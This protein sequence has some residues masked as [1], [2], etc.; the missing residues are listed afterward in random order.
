MPMGTSHPCATDTV[1]VL[2]RASDSV[3]KGLPIHVSV[4]LTVLVPL[5]VCLV[6]SDF[7]SCANGGLSVPIGPL[8]LMFAN[9]IHPF[10]VPIRL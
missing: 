9:W 5:G 10:Y 6:S 1:Y 2:M 3:P 4:G 7:Q 8:I